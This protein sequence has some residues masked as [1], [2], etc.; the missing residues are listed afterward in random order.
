MEAVIEE[1]V[2]II[3]SASVANTLKK[4]SLGSKSQRKALMI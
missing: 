1:A 3:D 4:L 2:E